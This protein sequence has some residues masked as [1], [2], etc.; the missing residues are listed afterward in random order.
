MQRTCSLAT[1]P[2]LVLTARQLKIRVYLET[3][4]TA[5]EIL[6]GD[7]P[8]HDVSGG[9]NRQETERNLTDLLKSLVQ[10]NSEQAV[11][12]RG[13]EAGAYKNIIGVL[14]ICTDAGITNV[15]FATAK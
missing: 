4:G 8:R 14:N 3:A 13:D 12:I 1:R 7:P 9:T 6:G 10:L 5:Q 15:A 2:H 11:I